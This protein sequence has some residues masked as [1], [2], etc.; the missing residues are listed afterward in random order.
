MLINF[1][2]CFPFVYLIVHPAI[3]PKVNFFG[4]KIILFIISSL[5]FSNP[6]SKY[7]Q[8]LFCRLLNFK[9]LHENKPNISSSAW[10]APLKN[11]S[12]SPVSSSKFPTCFRNKRH[13]LSSLKLGFLNANLSCKIGV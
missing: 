1:A 9:S 2:S 4:P 12:F 10:N 8:I 3:C 5:H 6:N 13:S 11:G 7:E